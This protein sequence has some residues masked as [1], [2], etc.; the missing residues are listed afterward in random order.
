MWQSDT[1]YWVIQ[2]FNFLS[3]SDTSKINGKLRTE[4]QFFLAFC[5]NVENEESTVT[6]FYTENTA[7][8]T[9]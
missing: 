1:D 6:M 4:K 8:C 9:E 5:C 2:N 7:F 3:L